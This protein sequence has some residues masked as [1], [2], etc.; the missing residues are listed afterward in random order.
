[1]KNTQIIEEMKNRNWAALRKWLG[2][3]NLFDIQSTFIMM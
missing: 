1:M 2:D 3:F